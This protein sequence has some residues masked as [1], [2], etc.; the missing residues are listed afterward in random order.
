MRR[1]VL[2]A[3]Q[4]DTIRSVAETILRQNGYDVI[5]VT[6]A[7]K[8]REV[9]E[10]S[11][12]DLIIIGADL[13]AAD[14]SPYHERIRQDPKA[15]GVPMLF[16]EPSDKAETAFPDEVVIPRPFD[17]KDFLQKVTIFMGD[18]DT[19]PS[20][21][22]GL[23]DSS[24]DDQFLDA[25]LGLDH[26]D[27]IDSEVM[28]QTVVGSQQKPKAAREKLI[29]L[30]SSV[31]MEDTDTGVSTVESLV[32]DEGS[33]QIKQRTPGRRAPSPDGTGKIEILSDQ[34]G[35]TESKKAD[36]DENGVHDYDWFIDAIKND[37]D[38]TAGRAAPDVSDSGSLS[39]T[40]P[41][42]TVNPITPEPASPSVPADGGGVN[43][44]IDEFK[45]E[46]EQV[47]AAESDQFVSEAVASLPKAG[48]KDLAWEESLE[49]TD[50]AQINWK[51]LTRLRSICLPRNSPANWAGKWPRLL[52][53]R[54]TP[55]NSSV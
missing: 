15:S 26:L 20:V 16:F 54:L 4:A 19:S 45:K 35:L 18:G 44:F 53:P 28:D 7:E 25:A 2:I 40:G 47:R 1:R 41:S 42:A 46:M 14:G 43:K 27:V 24:V 36:E 34:Y 12:P 31:D 55:I 30:D 33:S 3:E 32:I 9:L 51:K 37:H 48:S 6:A 10:L 5:A 22:P 39:I 29:G 38:Q 49:K 50:P 52:R 8:A 21:T 23:D 17:P 13:M 11:R